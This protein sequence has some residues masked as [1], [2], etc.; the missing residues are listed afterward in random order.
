MMLVSI[1]CLHTILKNFHV[2]YNFYDLFSYA[3]NSLLNSFDIYICKELRIWPLL[4]YTLV[5]SLI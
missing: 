2:G 3:V 1:T 4:Y 5:R